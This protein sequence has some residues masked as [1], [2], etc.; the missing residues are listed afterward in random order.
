MSTIADIGF[1]PIEINLS[2][3]HWGLSVFLTLVIKQLPK[4]KQPW[5]FSFLIFTFKVCFLLDLI[6][7]SFSGFKFPKPAAYKSLAIPRT[8]RQS[9]LFG[10]I[11]KSIRL[12]LDLEK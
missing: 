5:F 3:N 6:F 2:F 9:G 10:V 8:P 11:D 12:E 4:D 7:L 1:W